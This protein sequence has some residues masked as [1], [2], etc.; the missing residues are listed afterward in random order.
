MPGPTWQ[1]PSSRSRA[2]TLPSALETI[3]IR[4]PVAARAGSCSIR[5]P[6]VAGPGAGGGQ[7]LQERHFGRRD[8]P[9]RH[10]EVADHLLHVGAHDLQVITVEAVVTG[11]PRIVRPREHVGRELEAGSPQRLPHPLLGREVED[12]ADVQEDGLDH[13]PQK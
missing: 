12:A 7:R 6:Q 5:L 3:A 2:S 9:G 11:H 4:A 1:T 10:G 8:L 13:F